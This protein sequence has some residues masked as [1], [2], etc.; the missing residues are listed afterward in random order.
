[1]STP[2]RSAHTVPGLCFAL[3]LA[4]VGPLQAQVPASTQVMP[5]P[6]PSSSAESPD[7]SAIT[8]L[9][10]VEDKIDTASLLGRTV[11]R[12]E[13]AGNRQIAAS[14][15]LGLLGTRSGDPLAAQRV[16]SDIE[17]VFSLGFFSDVAVEGAPEGS[18]GVVVT[19]RVV[20]LPALS[21]AVGLTGNHKVVKET[22]LAHTTGMV[23]GAFLTPADTVRARRAM[24]S[25]YS[26]EG[27]LRA[28]VVPVEVVDKD[29]ETSTPAVSLTF[30][31]DEGRKTRIRKI[32]FTGNS[33]FASRTLRGRL[34]SEERFW[35]TSWL[36]GSGVFR[37]THIEEDLVRL[38]DFYQDRGFLDVSVAQPELSLSSDRLWYTVTYP[39]EEGP[40]YHVGKVTY[41]HG[42]VV[43]EADLTRKL[44]LPTGTLFNRS[45]LRGN[46]QTISDRL[47][48]RGYAFAQVAP[49][50]HRD[51]V[52]G[53]VD[54]DYNIQE[55]SQIRIRRINIHGNTK[56][57]D[58]VIRREIRQQEGEIINTALLRR[59][60]QRI[61]N[62]QYF[63]D[64]VDINTVPAGPDLLDVD[65]TVEE[66]PTGQFSIGGGYSSS[67]G[68]VGMTEITQGNLG[69]R[70][71]SLSGRFERSGRRTLYN[72]RFSEPHIFDSSYS[73][74]F[75]LYR[76]LRDFQTYNEKRVGGGVTLGKAYG[77]YLSGSLSYRYEILNLTAPGGTSTNPVIN[78]QLGQSTS[79]TV[80][81]GIARDT[82][83]NFMDPR[84]G[85]RHAMNAEVGG[86]YLGGTHDYIKG[87]LD[88]VLFLPLFKH[89]SF[90]LRSQ[91]GYGVGYNGQDLPPGERFFVGGIRTVRGFNW[92][93]AG[94]LDLA[95]GD[96]YGGDKMLVFSS[97]ITFPLV[98]EA[99]IKG[100]LFVDYGAGF[101]T[102][103]SMDVGELNGG[104]GWEIRWMSPV[105][106][107]RFGY[108]KVVKDTRPWALRRSGDQFFDFGTFF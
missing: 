94:P 77:E 6:T 73:A 21:G 86:G 14:T 26:S 95:S 85:S 72:L 54:I 16:R 50:F 69:G 18:N 106:P 51:P 11:T 82:R 92:G 4:M 13:I 8:D 67:D 37:Q 83:D 30:V 32:D 104:I 31:V 1:M 68:L 76:S 84:H 3:L 2:I 58:K 81:T 89:S 53:V 93:E 20:E 44:D 15:V 91:V 90:A 34:K 102:S 75:D 29:P 56:T 52:T 33:S 101:D 12:V 17:A 107:L 42:G 100:A 71:Q 48:E 103:Q 46:I 99:N 39:I 87:V 105:G 66:K 22:L 108:G 35:A 45:T 25:D 62:L 36:T 19:V 28:R 70:G 27:F 57:R 55:G 43:P 97:E 38:E 47:G 98:T 41:R 63:G 74:G 80:G 9:I 78:S 60:F 40:V 65:I 88:D 7:P 61:R 59:S 64:A 96:P 23:E 10:G 49:E 24:L 79:S 5:Q